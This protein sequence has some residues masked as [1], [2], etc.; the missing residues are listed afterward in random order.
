[1]IFEI[2]PEQIEKLGD[3]DLR[4]LVGKMAEQELLRQG[5]P[6]SGVTYGGHQNAADG[7]IDVRVDLESGEPS[8]YVPRGQTGLQVKAENF[9]RNAILKEMRPGQKLRDSIVELAEK[10]GAY[11]IV[12]SKGSVSDTSLRNRRNAMQEALEDLPSSGK[13]FVDFYDRRRIASWVNQNPGLI[14]WVRERSGLPLSGWQSFGDWSSSPGP[15]NEDY[16]SDDKLCLKHAHVSE[17]RF[18]IVEGINQ[19]RKILSENHGA[20]RLVGLSGVGKTR[21]AQA[22]FDERIGSNPISPHTAVY[23]DLADEPNPIPL[24]LL[25][26]ILSL[27]QR[28]ILIVDNSGIELHRKLV[29]RMSRS[30]SAPVSIVTIEYD[31]SDD[32]PENT[33]VFK[34]E[35]ASDEIIEKIISRR[36]TKLTQPEVRTIAKFSEGNFRIALALAET[37]RQGQ[38]LANL[39]DSELFKRLFRQ[40]ND[41]NPALLGAA[42]ASSLVYS[43]DGETLEGNDAEL[44]VLAALAEQSVNEFHGHIAELHRRQLV[45]KRT[46]WRAI[47]PHAIAHRLAKQ[48]LQDIPRQAILVAF[49]KQGPE[50]LLKSFSR[51][52]GYLHDSPEAQEIV[53]EWLGSGGCLSKVE[54]L[55]ELGQTLLDN[56]APV[57]PAATLECFESSAARSGALFKGSIDRH[58]AVKLLRAIAYESQY[59]ERAVG[60]IV[61]FTETGDDSNKVGD[62]INVFKSLFMLYLSGTQA[63]P[64]VRSSVIIKLANTENER[65]ANLA[66][67]GLS[68][69]FQTSHFTSSYGFDFGTRKRDYGYQPR[70]QQDIVDWFSTALKLSR[71]MARLPHLKAQVRKMV[72][73][74]LPSLFQQLTGMT[75]EIVAL[76]DEFA[77]DGGWPEG[78]VAARTSLRRLNAPDC[79]VDLPKIQALVER[80]K[81]T[82]LKDRIASYVSPEGWGAL[83]VVDARFTDQDKRQVATEAANKV[84]REI[85][86]E[87]ASDFGLLEEHLPTLAEARSYRRVTVIDSLAKH[88]TDISKT[89]KLVRSASLAARGAA[90][91]DIA[92]IFV[93][94]VAAQNC[95]A[96][97][98]ILDEA[99]RD[100]ALHP[101]LINMQ[102]NAGLNARGVKR[103]LAAAQIATVPTITFGH[104]AYWVKWKER[105]GDELAQILRAVEQREDGL[106]VA[107]EI[108]ST[109]ACDKNNPLRK[110][111]KEMGKELVMKALYNQGRDIKGYWLATISEACLDKDCD[112][113]TAR[114]ICG[115]LFNSVIYPSDYRQLVAVLTQKFP[116]VVLDELVGVMSDKNVIPE[117]VRSLNPASNIDHDTMFK[118]VEEEPEMRLLCLAQVIPIWEKADGTQARPDE[119]DETTEPIRWTSSAERI[120]RSSRDIR[121]LL[122]IFVKRFSP[123][124]WGGSRAAILENRAFLLQTLSNDPE[125]QIASAAEDILRRYRRLVESER[126]RE[127]REARAQDERF[128]W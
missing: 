27:G 75:N 1:M 69:M 68:T 17:D 93:G 55:D 102:V 95:E 62:G 104:L 59:F 85:G 16:F 46:H 98:S 3:S 28:C 19:L 18:G 123:S 10:N 107:V 109:R 73:D 54:N 96:A 124:S 61:R 114:E 9:P 44:P 57:S 78:W 89:W 77:A 15:E 94:G 52:L 121:H 43:F 8:G 53:S 119:L 71:E 7:G 4:T 63:D 91:Y 128:E 80:L 21:L 20:I 72:A 49:T 87:L 66:L 110:P 122:E 125:H 14:P 103:V 12:S 60:L 120:I 79:T 92:G 26:N 127:A 11:I 64:G 13:L 35:P 24:E 65:D 56:V 50:R 115:G 86:Q 88:A 106:K 70:S 29:A 100:E 2:T 84:A 118:W 34:L 39:N 45:Q 99:L 32:A 40:R 6:A 25:E 81:P 22:L 51:R 101:G 30:S 5:F 67:A 117:P 48:A 36:Y 97:E 112:E 41:D 82:T 42:L 116:T 38:S 111:E 90:N 33:E 108:M 23:T 58:S 47:L 126:E 105:S 113:I 83:D 76:A 37:A 31:I 74:K